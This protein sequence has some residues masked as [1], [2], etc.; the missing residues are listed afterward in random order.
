M[1][2]TRIEITHRLEKTQHHFEVE[3]P[4]KLLSSEVDIIKN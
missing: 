4:D 2:R 3:N 1:K